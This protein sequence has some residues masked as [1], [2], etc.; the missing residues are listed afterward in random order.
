MERELRRS[1]PDTSHQ[2]MKTA[3]LTAAILVSSVLAIWCHGLG[4]DNR[5]LVYLFKPLTTA[6][7]LVLALTAPGPLLTRYKLAIVIGLAFSLA[8]DVFLM[9]PGDLFLAGLSS[10]LIAH[11]AYLVAFTSDARL[12]GQRLPF[13]IWIPIGV[14]NIILLW[15]GIPAPLRIPV[16]LYTA[17]ILTMA[18]QA[19]SRALT[20]RLASARAAAIG[21][22]LFVI[23]DT[24]IGLD[25]FRPNLD[26]S[27]VL[28]LGTYY[29]AQWLIALSIRKP[30]AGR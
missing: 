18:A 22:A 24:L 30:G 19:A 23:S 28:V 11:I 7:I 20:L 3:T 14:A 16:V 8:G 4:P 2:H 6:L 25:R 27:P 5:W 26:F 21:A 10:F 12:G 17:I 29:A 13:L 1:I 15:P 9:L